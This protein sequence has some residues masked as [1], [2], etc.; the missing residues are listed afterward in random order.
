MRNDSLALSNEK[1][2]QQLAGS[3]EEA[4]GLSVRQRSWF[5]R[6]VKRSVDVLVSLLV[7][8]L[9]F[10]FFLAIAILIK[11]TSRGPV[12]FKQRRVGC[13]GCTFILYKFRTMKQGF[14]DT[15]HREFTKNFINGHG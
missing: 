2:A 5:E 6:A 1:V 9:G 15:V 14:D 3:L 13:K 4:T 7:L 10:P 12:F 8:V 11:I